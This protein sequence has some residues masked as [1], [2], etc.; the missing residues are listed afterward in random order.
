EEYRVDAQNQPE[1]DE[2]LDDAG[3]VEPDLRR[4]EFCGDEEAERLGHEE[5]GV[6]MRNEKERAREAQERYP[7]RQIEI[8]GNIHPLT[9]PPFSSVESNGSEAALKVRKGEA[10]KIADQLT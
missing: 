7:V 6:D 1:G 8:L 3:A 4:V 10:A 5:L 9:P 2:D